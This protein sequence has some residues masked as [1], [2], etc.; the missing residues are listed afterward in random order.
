MP[1]VAINPENG[2]RL[3]ELPNH[4][5]GEL[6]ARITAAH[7]ASHPQHALGETLKWLRLS[8]G[9]VHLWPDSAENPTEIAR[10]RGRFLRGRKPPLSA[11]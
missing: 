4:S 5:H 9:S 3:G 11:A 8:P 1:F 2:Q 7:A 6:Q 10:H